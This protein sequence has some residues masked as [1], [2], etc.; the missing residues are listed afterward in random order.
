MIFNKDNIVR[1]EFTE[2]IGKYQFEMVALF[3][4]NVLSEEEAVKLI[5]LKDFGENE[6]I[7]F[8]SKAQFENVFMR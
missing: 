6:N 8:M 2:T 4:K 1:I 3:N 5:K 7:I